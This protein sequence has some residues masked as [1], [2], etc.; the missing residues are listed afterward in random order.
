MSGYSVERDAASGP[1]FDATG[2][3]RLLIR[4]C[5]VC[6]TAYPP[7][8]RRCHDSDQLDWVAASG[9]GVLVTWAVDH[10]PPLDAV[11]ASPDGVTSTFGLVELDEGPWWQVPIVGVDPA[12]LHEGIA[13]T[14]TFV[15]PGEGEALAAFTRA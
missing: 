1:F 10:A 2:Q 7:H 11:L 15:R 9:N 5:P 13:M 4:R 8:Q 6:G 12:S 3:G 14:V